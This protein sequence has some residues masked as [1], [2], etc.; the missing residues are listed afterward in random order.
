MS[1]ISRT[2]DAVWAFVGLGWREAAADRFGLFGRVLLYSLPVLIFGAI[3]R[4][5][6]LAE[7]GHDAERL[8]WYVMVTEAVIFAPGF[9]F[10]EIEEDIRS[11]AIE[12][13]LTRPL[14]YGLAR[15]AE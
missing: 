7:S 13:A 15:V 5:T 4:A 1:E 6:P 2:L 3:W 10:R 9:V 12:A 8:T 11:G 14:A